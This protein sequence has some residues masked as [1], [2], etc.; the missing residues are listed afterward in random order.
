MNKYSKEYSGLNP[1]HFTVEEYEGSAEVYTTGQMSIS[2]PKV[3]VDLETGCH[4][5]LDYQ[6]IFA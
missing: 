3:G 4:Q 5:H 6:L 1:P 2:V